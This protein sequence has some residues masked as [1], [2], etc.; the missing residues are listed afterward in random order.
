MFP[1]GQN[2]EQEEQAG[3]NH[4]VNMLHEDLTENKSA[5][6][7]EKIYLLIINVFNFK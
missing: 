3:R 1:D 4:W 5:K 7:E 6:K 2:G